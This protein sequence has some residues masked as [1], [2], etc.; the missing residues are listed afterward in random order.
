[1]FRIVT[2]I[3]NII[4]VGCLSAALLLGTYQVISRY[5]FGSGFVW[6]E[7]V[8]VLL[9]IWAVLF[10][11]SRAIKDRIHARVGIL[12][13]AL[14]PKPRQVVNVVVILLCLGFCITL[15]YYGLQYVLFMYGTGARSLRVQIPTWQVFLIVPTFFAFFILRYLEELITVLRQRDTTLSAGL[16]EEVSEEFLEENLRIKKDEVF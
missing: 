10:G 14:P 2:A 4:M 8:I 7:G 3:E 6:M 5:I 15:F 13:D 12:V 11:G 9:T 16:T 1:M